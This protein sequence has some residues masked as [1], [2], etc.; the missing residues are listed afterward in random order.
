MPALAIAFGCNHLM[1]LACEV[2]RD[3]TEEELARLDSTDPSERRKCS[4]LAPARDR[5]SDA[6]WYAAKYVTK[7]IATSQAANIIMVMSLLDGYFLRGPQEERRDTDPDTERR[8]GFGNIMACANR[9]TTSIT[10]GLAMISYRLMGHKTYWSSYDVKPMPTHA[11]TARALRNAGESDDAVDGGRVEVT[12]VREGNELRGVTTLHDYDHRA[13]ELETLPPY[14]YYMFYG[15]QA[16]PKP[17]A[18]PSRSTGRPAKRRRT[19]AGAAAAAFVDAGGASE[20][21]DSEGEDGQDGTVAAPAADGEQVPHGNSNSCDW[22]RPR[23]LTRKLSVQEACTPCAYASSCTFKGNKSTPQPFPTTNS[24]SVQLI[25][26]SPATGGAA[27]APATIGD[28]LLPRTAPFQKDHPLHTSHRAHRYPTPC[29]PRFLGVLPER[30]PVDDP[31]GEAALT[32]YAFVIG[33]FRAHRVNPL[34]DGATLRSAYEHFV[35]VELQQAP[36]AYREMITMVLTNIQGDH[37]S[38]RRRAEQKAQRRADRRSKGLAPG[39]YSSSGEDSDLDGGRDGELRD[40]RMEVV[41]EGGGSEDEQD[42]GAFTA[43]AAATLE[44]VAGYD[45]GRLRARDMFDLSTRQGNYMYGAVNAALKRP[46]FP[47]GFGAHNRGWNK[48]GKP[49]VKQAMDRVWSA[50]QNAKRNGDDDAMAPAAD[51]TAPAAGSSLRTER[52][53]GC[54]LALVDTPAAGGGLTTTAL[55][56]GERPPMIKMAVPPTKEDTISL[57]TL[58]EEQAFAFIIFI[59]YFEAQTAWLKDKEKNPHPGEP[60]RVL[61][62]GK[63]GTGKSQVVHAAQWY[64]FQHN[65]PSWFATCS[66]AWTAALAF[67]HH[68]HRSLSTHSM[69]Q[70]AAHQGGGG[71]GSGKGKQGKS[72]TSIK[73]TSAAQLQVGTVR[74]RAD[75]RLPSTCVWYP[76]CSRCT[77]S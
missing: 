17:K 57:F 35:G 32:Y 27:A 69:F 15:R 5:A 11:L 65:Q 53:N 49:D 33:N 40:A 31:D 76:A 19:G 46:D 2:D 74:F 72:N 20:D 66:Y 43:G 25:H 8:R 30:P 38:K 63:P 12:L 6:A 14:A 71:G 56:P 4:L 52:R 3:A 34:P 73:I 45:L 58:S 29:F 21:S 47:D 60:P 68:A 70:L 36:K 7:A 28:T 59:D 55:T 10:M 75:V 1:S 9:L 51:G 39:G 18:K 61:M 50:Q 24:P 62:V 64:V 22:P 13:P 16:Q 77:S 48:T 41:Q 44:E 23:T 54:L 67:S 42:G 37:D 26:L